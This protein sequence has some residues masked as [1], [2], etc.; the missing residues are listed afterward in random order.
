[1]NIQEEREIASQKIQRGVRANHGRWGI[2]K[3]EA[4][5]KKESQILLYPRM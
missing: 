2:N 5:D 3:L 1:L 4:K